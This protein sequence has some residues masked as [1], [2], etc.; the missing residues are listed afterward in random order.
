MDDNPSEASSHNVVVA[1]S[2]A[3]L[4]RLTRAQVFARDPEEITQAELEFVIAELTKINL[5]NRKARKDDEAVATTTAKIKKANAANK[6]QKK[7]PALAI[8]IMETKL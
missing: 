8:D 7:T 1:D 2:P 5:R 3:P 4:E 6:K